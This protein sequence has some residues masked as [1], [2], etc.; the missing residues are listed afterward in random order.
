MASLD[1]RV[2]CNNLDIVERAKPFKLL[3]NLRNYAQNISKFRW[4]QYR[5]M[6][7]SQ[8]NKEYSWEAR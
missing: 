8:R 7:Y 6:I 2:E 4:N 3:V 5:Y 1:K